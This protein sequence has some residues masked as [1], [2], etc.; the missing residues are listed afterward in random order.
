MNKTN[1]ILIGMMGSGKSTVGELLAQKLAYSFIDLDSLLQEKAGRTIKDI[2]DT[3][4]L[5]YFREL[6]SK[7]LESVKNVQRTV[8]STGG[9][10]ILKPENC[11]VLQNLGSIVWLDISVQ[12][13]NERLKG[14]L[15]RPL[16]QAQSAAERLQKIS[17]IMADRTQK[18]RTL[19]HLKL[20]VDDLTP[21]EIVQKIISYTV[22]NHDY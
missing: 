11:T 4:G 19:A 14:N 6:E 13:T 21:E 17:S 18:Y 9:G 12:A 10:V 3:T 22:Q 1:I 8:I 2:V 16:I 15:D 20:K 7:T 5:P